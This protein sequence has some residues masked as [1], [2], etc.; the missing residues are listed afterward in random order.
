MLPPAALRLKPPAPS[1]Q[2]YGWDSKHTAWH[3]P[4]ALSKGVKP[5]SRLL[6]SLQAVSG[7]SWF[8]PLACCSAE[9][10]SARFFT[11]IHDLSDCAVS[12]IYCDESKAGPAEIVAVIPAGRRACVRPDFAFEFLAFCRFLGVV[13]AGHECQVHDAIAAGIAEA[14]AEDHLVF[15]FSSGMWPED[16]DHVLS[17]CVEQVAVSLCKWL[18]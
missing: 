5:S 2:L 4:N 7:K 3:G 18:E 8:G 1:V 15:S 11:L 6:K 9:Q 13:D 16:L 17:C 12:I 14:P 10:E